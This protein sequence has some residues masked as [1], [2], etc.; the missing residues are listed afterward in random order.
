MAAE[1]A[2]QP[3]ALRRLLARRDGLRA[4]LAAAMPRDLRGVALVGRG[5]SA[6]AALFGRTL[7]EL[8]TGRPALLVSPSAGRLYDV[9]T[10]YRGYVAVGLSQSGRTPEVVATL[11]ELHRSGARTVAVTADADSPLAREADVL[12]DLGVGAERAVPT[13]KAFTAQLAA[14]VV[15]AEALGGDVAS[16]QLWDAAACATESVLADRAPVQT[17]A[18]SLQPATHLAVVGAGLFL[19]IA[20]EVALK[21]QETAVV[22][23]AAHSSASYRHGPFALTGKQHPLVAVVGPGPAGVET[24]RLVAD[25]RAAGAPV[26]VIGAGGDLSVPGGLPEALAAIP[27]VVRGQQLALELAL[28]RGL[29]PDSPPGLSKVT[30]T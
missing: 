23:A 29:D 3:A 4:V 12:V 15:L 18:R 1:M 14:L 19:G 9:R 11:D 6:N 7:A 5:S 16:A 28:A 8:A 22:A 27:A 20:E 30:D 10:D 21:L 26:V 17:A 13:T 25:A 24:T 2:E